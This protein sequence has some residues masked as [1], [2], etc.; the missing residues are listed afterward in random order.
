MK[1]ITQDACDLGPCTTKSPQTN[2]ISTS[3][4]SAQWLF[5]EWSEDVGIISLFIQTLML[6]QAVYRNFFT[7]VHSVPRSAVSVCRRERC[8][9]KKDRRKNFATNRQDQKLREPVPATEPVAD[10]GL[11]DPGPR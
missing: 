1:P 5:T 2:A 10:N 3:L 6:F 4:E 9:A 11:R 8:S 7:Y